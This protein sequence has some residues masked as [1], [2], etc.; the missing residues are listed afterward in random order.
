[1]L[2]PKEAAKKRRK[3]DSDSA[4]VT[5][6]G[7]SDSEDSLEDVKEKKNEPPVPPGME[8]GIK[9]LYREDPRVAWDDW[10]PDDIDLDVEDNPEAK[11]W[12]LIVRREKS[13]NGKSALVLHSITVQSPLLKKF[14]G[15]VFDGYQGISTKLQELTFSTPFH[16]FFYRWDRFQTAI[17]DEKEELTLK[18]VNL[19]ENVISTE[20]KP[21]L[22]KRED[23]LKHGLVTFDY[24]WALFEPDLDIWSEVDEQNRLYK[25]S[26][27]KY[28][29]IQ[30]EVF[31]SLSSR[32]IDTNGTSFGCVI[33]N[34]VI[35]Y[36]EGIRPV[37]SLNVLPA[38]LHPHIEEIKTKLH[39][40]GDKFRNLNG[41]HYKSYSGFYVMRKIMFGG[42]N[43][44]N[45]SHRAQ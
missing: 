4:P 12:A 14:L 9:D 20:I 21:H 24:L 37:T 27:S 11:K 8:I 39:Q 42:S 44:R 3:K 13:Q 31:F 38:H 22:E 32:Y 23:L 34:L 30:N 26:S 16:E 25:L 1:M 40:R 29:K 17:K 5:S 43:K 2:K 19:L 10:C 45:V 35:G 33:A 36:F 6:D 7:R 41:L 18:H 28:Q 15:P